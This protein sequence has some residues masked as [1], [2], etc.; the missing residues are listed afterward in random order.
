MA[1][2]VRWL[3]A[4]KTPAVRGVM[5]AVI[6]ELARRIEGDESVLFVTG[7]GVS[8]DSGLPTYR[9]IGGLY[10]DAGTDD[11]VPI[12]QALSG[13]MFRRNPALTWKY[14][15]Q[16]EEASRGAGPN[17]AH[18]VIGALQRRL[19]RCVVLTQNVDGLH[20]AGGATD[21]IAIHGDVHDLLC[22]ECRRAERVADYAALAPLPRC[23][24]GGVIRPK[25]VLFG[26]ML[27]TDAADRLQRELALGFDVV[28]S[29]G[30]T[31]VFP[32]IAAPVVLTRE[33]GGLTVEVN[34][35][36]SEVSRVVHHRLRVGAAEALGALG[37][38]LGL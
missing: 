27:P 22:T 33:H 32:Y 21:V 15:R 29:V 9:G 31:S 37:D 5:D 14:I 6:Q 12:E 35:G 24:C 23:G 8:A 11:G 38:R 19:T 34:P 18:A 36:E 26:E 16:I 17:R 4:G 20:E 30:T 13:P 10:N 3:P 25:V 2:F 7:A 28:V 1:S